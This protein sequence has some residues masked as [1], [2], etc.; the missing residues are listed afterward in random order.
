MTD[1]AIA[2]LDHYRKI[3]VDFDSD[4]LWEGEHLRQNLHIELEVEDQIGAAKFE[5]P[6]SRKASP[7][8]ATGT[9]VGDPAESSQVAGG[10]LLPSLLELR[11]QSE[12]ALLAKAEEEILACVVSPPEH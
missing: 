3:D 12:K 6:L 4:I 7:E 1:S 8:M 10:D 11:E 2:F 9:D 5:R